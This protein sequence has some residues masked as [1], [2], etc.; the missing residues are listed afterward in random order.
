MIKSKFGTTYEFSITV[1]TSVLND[2]WMN[3]K[4]CCDASKKKLPSIDY[5][6]SLHYTD[7]DYWTLVGI[8]K[9]NF[10]SLCNEII[11]RTIPIDQL[12]WQSVVFL[13]N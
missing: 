2:I 6:E 4:Y 3:W 1:L 12:I 7:D 10:D 9:E 11:M 8:N 13:L 5:N